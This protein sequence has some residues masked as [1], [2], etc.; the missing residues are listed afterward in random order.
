MTRALAAFLLAA[1]LGVAAFAQP[2]AIT[3]GRV[4]TNTDAG[5][6]AEAT[7]IID[8]GRIVQ[9]G[10]AIPPP[11]GA[12][13]IDA[14][15][16]WVTP[17]LFAALSQLGMVEVSAEDSTDDSASDT[18]KFSIALDAA[19]GF[20]PNSSAIAVSRIEGLTRAAI[21]TNSTKSIFGGQG[22]L[23]DTSGKPSSVF[24]ARK[25]LFV[26]LGGADKAGGTRSST[27]AFLEAAIRDARAFPARY[28][29]DA[30]GEV[31]SRADAEAFGPYLQGQGLIVASA[32]RADDLRALAALKEREPQLKLVVLGAN[33]ASLAAAEL[34]RASVGV[35]IDPLNNLP[36]NFDSIASSFDTPAA[37]RKAG[38]AFAITAA[39]GNGGGAHNLRL[40]PQHAGN[41]VAHGLAWEDAFKAISLN[42][43]E[44]YGVADEL[45]SLAPGKR[46]DVVI[47]DGDP[48]E[49]MS[50][51]ERV[52]IDGDE[53]A[54]VSR[55]TR[56]RDRYNPKQPADAPPH[57]Y[58]K[59]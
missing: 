11:E 48:L 1:S 54:L 6:L 36:Q 44:I 14:K 50:A 4:V 2:I 33:E 53:T 15:G 42:P 19:K 23:V 5:V 29:A 12:A 43:A 37:L 45:G 34:A 51:P 13:I 18:P 56:L 16:K 21:M 49:V 7:V 52:F 10:A 24:A 8:A 17:G 55:Q 35:F 25:F 27:A 46:A 28:A 3:G 47:W 40:L 30:E 20:N 31:L 32:N 26:S 39:T 9:V 38:V 57:A 59:P 22:A 58:R 41:A